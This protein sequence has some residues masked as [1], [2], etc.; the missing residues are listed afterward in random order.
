M[1]CI[2][3]VMFVTTAGRSITPDEI[4]LENEDSNEVTGVVVDDDDN[5]DNC[6]AL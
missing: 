3:V 4:K 6:S 5:C 1:Y 2:E